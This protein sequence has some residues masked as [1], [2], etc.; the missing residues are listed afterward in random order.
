LLK[1]RVVLVKAGVAKPVKAG[2]ASWLS[3]DGQT[4]SMYEPNIVK[5]SYKE[6][7]HEDIK[8]RIYLESTLL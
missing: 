3:R 1:E 5:R 2:V 7:Q 8:T 6:P 4:C